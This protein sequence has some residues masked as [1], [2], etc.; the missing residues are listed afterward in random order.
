[1]YYR[2][3]GFRHTQVEPRCPVSP[4][5]T[6]LAPAVA[7]ALSPVPVASGAWLRRAPAPRAGHPLV[8]KRSPRSCRAGQA[9]MGALGMSTT[10]S[11][12]CALEQHSVGLQ[13]CLRRWQQL[14]AD[15]RWWPGGSDACQCRPVAVGRDST[16][17]NPMA[18]LR[19]ADL[20][21]RVVVPSCSGVQGKLQSPSGRQ[22][23]LKVRQ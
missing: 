21:S 8:P 13:C 15:H 5:H 3:K 1:M 9:G 14:G 16:L 6:D 18:H 17:Q 10:P 19:G 22:L 11:A 4:Q 2:I 23:C 12:P 7:G 20:G